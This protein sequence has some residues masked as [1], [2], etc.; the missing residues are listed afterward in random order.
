MALSGSSTEEKIWN[1]LRSKGLTSAGT[2]GLMGN[3][4]AESGLSPINLQN[5]YEKSL[6][7]SDS[8]YTLAVDKGSYTRFSKDNAGYGLAQWT[9][10]TRKNNLLNYA[11]SSGKSIGD[12]EMQLNF[13]YNELSSSYSGVLAILKST[14]SVREASNKVLLNFERPANQGSSV[15]ATRANYGQNYYDKYS[16]NSVKPITSTK[17]YKLVQ[18][19]KKHLG[20]PY[21]FGGNGPDTFD[22]SGFIKYVYN[23]AIDYGMT[24]RTAYTQAQL[25]KDVK[26]QTPMAGD[27]VFFINTYETGRTP[28]ISHVGMFIGEGDKFINAGDPV[29][30]ESLS[31]PKRKSKYYTTR[32]LLS[33]SETY[34]DSSGGVGGSFEYSSDSAIDTI[35]GLAG[36]LPLSRVNEYATELENALNSL[37]KSDNSYCSLIDLTRG[38]EF[39]FYLPENYTESFPISWDTNANIQGRSVPPTGYNNSGPRSIP[40]EIMLVAGA[41]YYSLPGKDLNS[42]MDLMYK[43]ISFIKSLTYPDYDYTIVQPPSLVLLSLGSKIKL[44]GVVSNLSFTYYK[45]VDSQS[46]SMRVGVSF[47][48]S[49]VSD[50]P[51]G[52]S[53]ILSN[54]IRSY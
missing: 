10:S 29:K 44:K 26:N 15:Q 2:A 45:P 34:S 30:I 52:R 35:T 20:K 43:D 23:T 22:C 4:F 13:L 8:S 25:G 21:T 5:S 46:R 50:E 47:T 24:A 38:G 19:A 12:L 53:D 18:E 6:G 32:R 11:K 42:V 33:E 37:S 39:K 49:Q 28:N 36:G 41:G 51:P 40:I 27:L 14:S 16:S 1:F 48:V 7:Y 9:Y 31:S 54:N 3:L 17:G